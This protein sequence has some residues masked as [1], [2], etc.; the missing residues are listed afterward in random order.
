MVRR[1]GFITGIEKGYIEKR[2]VQPRT[3]LRE[4]GND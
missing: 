3:G 4:R 2:N 1:R